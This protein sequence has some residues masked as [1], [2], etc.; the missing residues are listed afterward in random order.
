MANQHYIRKHTI[1]MKSSSTILYCRATVHY[2]DLDK[3]SMHDNQTIEYS[4]PSICKTVSLLKRKEQETLLMNQADT[5]VCI[6]VPKRVGV[7]RTML[8]LP[9]VDPDGE[10]GMYLAHYIQMT[11]I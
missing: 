2:L 9:E 1:L 11:C 6:V 8:L 10:L 4:T 5:Y 3:H 7:H